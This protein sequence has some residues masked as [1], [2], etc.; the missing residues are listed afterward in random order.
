MIE[1]QKDAAPSGAGHPHTPHYAANGTTAPRTLHNYITMEPENLRRHCHRRTLPT[2]GDD[3]GIGIVPPVI[4]VG[5][6]TGSEKRRH[7]T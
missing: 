4:G 3:I 5:M 1:A 2:T 6:G 7:L